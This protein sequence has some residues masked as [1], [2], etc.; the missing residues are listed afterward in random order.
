MPRVVTVAILTILV[1][2]CSRA[3]F[4]YRK[5][6]WLLEYYAWKAVDTSSVQRDDWQPLLQT[7]LRRHREQ[8]LPLV[9]AYLDQ[10]GHIIGE[11]DN[12]IGATCLVDGALLLYRRHARLAVDLAVPLLAD[13]DT[14]QIS[15]LREYTAQRQQ[16][17]IKHYLDPNPQRRKAA[18]QERITDRIENWTGKL[19]ASQQQL[20]KEA[21]EHIP[22]LSESWLA[23]RA[24][25]TDT[26]LTMLQSGASTSSLRDYLGDWWVHRGGTSA[27]SRQ[28]W[29][30]AMHGFIELMDNL[31]TT[32]TSRQR[33][34]LENRLGDLREDLVAFLPSSPGLVSLQLAPACSAPPDRL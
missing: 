8:E 26:L 24:Q 5:A 7:T 16:E 17:A 21:L 20:I 28:H 30:L 10:A 34:K 14:T 19:N 15:H 18:R 3:E 13:L 6:D 23:Y 22:D 4:S 29:Q 9:I 2:A 32:L 11:T 1:S 27:E 25:Q 12:A 33:K 31:A